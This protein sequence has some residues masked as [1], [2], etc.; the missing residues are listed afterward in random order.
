[1]SGGKRQRRAKRARAA[2]PPPLAVY[3]RPETHPFLREAKAKVLRRL[4]FRYRSVFSQRDLALWLAA[5]GREGDAIGILEYAY[6]T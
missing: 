3:E 6:A 2:P 1:M 4:N 5:L